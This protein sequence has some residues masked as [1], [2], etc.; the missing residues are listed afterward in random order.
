MTARKQ[1]KRLAAPKQ[2]RILRKDNAWTVKAAPGPHGKETSVPLIVLIRDYLKLT[3]TALEARRILK[4]KQVLVDGRA[5]TEPKFAVGFM[6]IITIPKME[7]AFRII[8]DYKG[9]IEVQEV[10]KKI[11]FKLA[12]VQNITQTAKGKQLTLHDGRNMITKEAIKTGDV[13]KIEVPSQKI[14]EHYPLK[15]GSVAYIT[16]G[17]HAGQTGKIKEV[18]E[19]T[20]TREKQVLFQ[21]EDSEFTAPMHYVFILGK[22]KPAISLGE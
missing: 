17:T 19:G 14:L 1:L 15:S 8:L 21:I 6:D 16:G 2:I 3:G 5:V 13:V 9:R 4:E 11:N 20:M 7:R 22:D 12:K 10:D 18:V